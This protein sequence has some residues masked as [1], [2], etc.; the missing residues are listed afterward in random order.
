MT[1][2]AMAMLLVAEGVALGSGNEVLHSC[3]FQKRMGLVLHLKLI[4]PAEEAGPHLLNIG[5]YALLAPY[6]RLWTYENTLRGHFLGPAAS[7]PFFAASSPN[8]RLTPKMAP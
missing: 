6:R 3:G 1:G 7:P 8:P 4:G 5:R 2:W